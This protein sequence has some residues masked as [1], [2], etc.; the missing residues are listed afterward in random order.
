[1]EGAAFLDLFAGTGANGIEALSR[2]ARIAVFVDSDERAIGAIRQNVRTARLAEHARITRLILP[3]G[4]DKLPPDAPSFDFIFAD[5]PYAFTDH[6]TL[7][8]GISDRGLLAHDGLIILEHSSRIEL[9]ERLGKFHNYRR[10]VYGDTG[11]T[12]FS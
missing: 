4:L 11:L 1:M 6:D 3:E 8:R 2:G 9:S 5:A 10:C 12:F 7:L